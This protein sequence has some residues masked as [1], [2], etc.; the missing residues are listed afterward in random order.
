V[1]L[2]VRV[3]L[4][5]ARS[6]GEDSGVELRR[7]LSAKGCNAQLRVPGNLFREGLVV[8]GF[9][10]FA[11]LIGEVFDERVELGLELFRAGFLFDAAFDLE[12]CSFAG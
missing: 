2:R 12:S 11:E 8:D 6:V 5:G 7:E 9:D 4:V 3:V 10:G 1:G